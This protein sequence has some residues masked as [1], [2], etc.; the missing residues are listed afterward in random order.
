MKWKSY[1]IGLGIGII[2]TA[3]I[4]QIVVGGRKTTMTEEEIIAQARSLGMVFASEVITDGQEATDASDTTLVTPGQ[5]LSTPGETLFASDNASFAAPDETAAQEGATVLS[6]SQGTNPAGTDGAMGSAGAQDADADDEGPLDGEAYGSGGG[7]SAAAGTGL[8][9]TGTS[10]SGTGSGTTSGTGTGTTGTGS[11]TSSGGA[12]GTG[13]GTTGGGTS[14]GTAATSL[15]EK[16]AEA[17]GTSGGTEES[18]SADTPGVDMGSMVMTIP[19]GVDSEGAARI[20]QDVG[21]IDDAIAFNNYLCRNGMD[22]YIRAGTMQVPRG[23]SY[24][25]VARVLTGR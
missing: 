5:T 16:E 23:A 18:A 7:T 2:V 21:L 3:V 6:A 13:S 17:A 25:E 11:S 15:A 24:E 8:S 4:M 14:S 20:L 12:S 9:G 1:L 19:S 22:R 10:G